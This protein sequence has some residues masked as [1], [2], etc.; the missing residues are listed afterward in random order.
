MRLSDV[1]AGT[2]AA[3]DLQRDPEIGLVTPDSRAVKPGALF[4][5]VK[6][7]KADGHAFARDAAKAGAAAVI[8]ERAV[9]CAPALLLLAANSRR[10][11]ALAAANFYGHPS[12][13]LAL[14]GVTG[15]NGKTTTTYLLEACAAAAGWPFGVLGTVSFR[16]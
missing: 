5:A 15:T 6:G 9:D 3:G 11:M 16:W 2:N 4:C 14:A 10:A 8:A 1:I 13:K 7:E 12:K